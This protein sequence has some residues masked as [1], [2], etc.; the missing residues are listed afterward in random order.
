MNKK[1]L[2]LAD[3]VG[4]KT[5]L[6]TQLLSEGM[7]KEAKVV[8]DIFSH[9]FIEVGGNKVKI[10][11]DGID[12]KDFDLVYF[13]R[14]DHAL[15]PLSG[16]LALCLDKLG[17]KY[18][19]TKFRDIGAGGDKMT[20]ITKLFVNGVP[21]PKTIFCSSDGILSNGGN[22]I[23][24]LGLPIIAKDTVTQGNKG[25]LV[26]KEEADFKRLLGGENIQ[27]NGR[28]TQFIFQK[29]IDMDKEYRV[30]VL[31]DK[32]PVVHTKVKRRYDQ[33]V[34]DY[35][36]YDTKL[37]F[38]DPDSVPASLKEIAIK[39]A[40]AL[41]TEIA[42]VDVCIEKKTGKIIVLEVNRGP[43]FDYDAKISPE[44]KEVVRFFKKEIGTE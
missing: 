23:S 15:F 17:I 12:I 11:I 3:K 18:F 26:I 14:I 34:L 31:K 10:F 1:I 28:P 7:G 4:P 38:V 2:I 33:F 36:S 37:E 44:I 27:S 30:L 21:V 5:E 25:V 42:G 20:S 29:Y 8:L 22:I 16:T 9:L 24:K 40:Q 19:D 39:A 41:D 13:R 43:G 32:V 35:E 6:F